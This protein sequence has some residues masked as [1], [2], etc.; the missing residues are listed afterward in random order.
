METVK[1]LAEKISQAVD[2]INTLKEEKSALTNKVS[3]LEA[4]LRQK[5]EEIKTLHEE[6]YRIKGQIEDL[7]KELD[8]IEAR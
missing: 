5:D 8:E 6:K 3:E 4:L 2:K 1:V 7:V